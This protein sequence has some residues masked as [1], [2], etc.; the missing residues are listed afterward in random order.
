MALINDT[1]KFLF[2]RYVV[3]EF[4]IIIGSKTIKLDTEQVLGFTI[5]DDYM[6]NLFPVFRVQLG[7]PESTYYK[8]IRNKEDVQFKIYLQA[9]YTK[10]T[11]RTKSTYTKIINDVYSLILDDDDEFLSQ[12]ANKAEYPNG[13]EKNMNAVTTAAE[14]FLFKKTLLKNTRKV[15]NTIL[16]KCTVSTAF[17]Y[18]FSKLG[19]KNLLM[20]KID[21]GA[22][23]EQTIVFPPFRIPDAIQWLDTYY[24]SYATGSM[25][26]LGLTKSYMLPFGGCQTVFESGERKYVCIIVPKIGGNATD[27]ICQ[28]SKKGDTQKYYVIADPQSFSPNNETTT[29]SIIEE[30][31][32]E[33]VDTE[34]DANG[35]SADNIRYTSKKGYNPFTESVYA[36]QKKS[37]ESVIEVFLKDINMNIITPNKIYQFLFEDTSLSKKYK[38]KYFLCSR[39]IMITKESKYYTLGMIC[40][41][42]KF[43]N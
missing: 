8:I 10:N 40:N 17:M 26:Y 3:K 23:S 20:K 9:Y 30:E 21:S 24:G 38:G 14:F 43:I 13:D 35:S 5:V 37:G 34:S 6:K 32:L 28:L 33:T 29:S 27:S 15:V 7:L 39:E 18:L 1:D 25:I 42:R 11:L 19:I 31:G 16:K 2:Y 22:N 12:D 36:A 4:Y 41:F